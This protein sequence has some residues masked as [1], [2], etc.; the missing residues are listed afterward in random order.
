[1]KNKKHFKPLT[2]IRKVMDFYYKRGVNSERINCLYKK[3]LKD[4]KRADDTRKYD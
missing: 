2:R 1:M 4:D 3:I